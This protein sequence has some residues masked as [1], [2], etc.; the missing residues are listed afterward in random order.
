[1]ASSGVV[2]ALLLPALQTA[3]EAARRAQSINNLR[4]IGLGLHTYQVT[5]RAF[6]VAASYDSNGRPLLSWRVH[7]LPFVGHGQLYEQFHLDEPWDSEHNTTLISKMPEFYKSPN[8]TAKEL[9]RTLYLAS[10]GEG[11]FLGPQP[12]RI[13][14]ITDG[15]SNT[16]AAVEVDD[17]QAVVWTKPED[18]APT[19][20]NPTAGIGNLRPSGVVVLFGDGSVW[21]IPKA[22]IPSLWPMI[23]IDGGEPRK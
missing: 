23:T 4:Q 2:I 7:I 14:E 5:H 9:G 21:T 10:V 1:M 17:D 3:R 15:L 13:A 12:R 16:L 6:P 20:A 8:Q 11:R 22:D 18:W 19:E